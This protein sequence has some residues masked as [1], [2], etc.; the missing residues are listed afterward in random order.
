MR[1]KKLKQKILLPFVCLCLIFPFLF[2]GLFESVG[3]AQAVIIGPIVGLDDLIIDDTTNSV[4][5]SNYNLSPATPYS[6]G[7]LRA[8]KY[9]GVYNVIR[10]T[11]SW[12]G[13]AYAS[14][15]RY[16]K[17]ARTDGRY[18]YDDDGILDVSTSRSSLADEV[19]NYPCYFYAIETTLP[20]KYSAGFMWT[21]QQAKFK[22]GTVYNFSM[23]TSSSTIECLSSSISTETTNKSHKLQTIIGSDGKIVTSGA[24][25]LAI[26]LTGTGQYE[27]TFWGNTGGDVSINANMTNY[28]ALADQNWDNEI[29]ASGVATGTFK[30][31]TAYY[32]PK[33][34]T[35][36]ASN[37]NN[38]V[39][40]NGVQATSQY[41]ST[42]APYTDGH[43]ITISDEGYTTV[44]YENGAEDVWST[45]YCF[46]DSTVPDVEYV[47][48]NSNALDTR[49]VGTI[50]TTSSGA[51]TQ[52]ITEGVFKD[53][54]QVI[55]SYDE[56]ESPETAT[57][58]YGG[59]TYSLTSG[60]WLSADGDYVVTITDAAG[61]TT[62]S[63]F[64]IDTSSPSY[65][66]ARLQSDTTYKV[67]KW[68]VVDIPYGYS[69]YGSYS[70][71]EYDDALAFAI[72]IER[73]NQVTEYTLSNINDFVAT[74]LV[75]SG[76]TVKTGNYWYYK[77]RDNPNL[78]VYYFDESSLEEVLEYYSKD[79]VSD[80]QVYKQNST[81]NPN[82][83]G[84]TLD[85]SMYDNIVQVDGITA[86][87]ANDFVFKQENTNES[88]KIYYSYGS[89]SSWIE[90]KY[91]TKFSS[92]VSTNGLYKI[93]EIDY[94][95]HETYYYIYLDLQSPLIDYEA[96]LYGSDKTITQ[97]ISV[98]DI[99]TNGELIF[100]YE[101]F[102]ITDVIEIDKWWTI[103]IKCP[104]GTTKR[105]TYLDEIPA[106][107]E[108]GTGEFTISVADRNNDAF[109]F[110]VCI[111][112]AA[113]EVTFTALNANSQLQIVIT[114]KDDAN[115]L[116]DL[117]IYRNDVC[118][119]SEQGYDEYPDITTDEL[120]YININTLKYVF[121]R[122]GIY[123]VEVTDSYGRTLTFEY[124]FEKDL[125]TGILSGVQHNGATNG[126]VTFTYNSSKYL[127]IVTQNGNSYSPTQTENNGT[128]ILYFSPT[129]DAE[130]L[131]NIELVE[132]TDTENYNIY[133]FTIDTVK[134]T[135][136]LYGVE[137]GGKTGGSVYATWDS[138]DEQY[139]ATYTLDGLTQEYKKGA[140]LSDAGAYVISLS[141]ELGNTATVSF[142]I[143][144]SVDFVIADAS[145]NTYQISEIEYINF[146]LR[147]VN[148]E[149]LTIS[150]TLDGTEIDYEFGLMITE[151]GYY[152]ATLVDEF[153]NQEYFSFTIDK[154]APIA[155]LYGVENYGIT[156]GSA[157]VA[158]QES[159]LTCWI[160]KDE[161]TNETYKLGTEITATGSYVI[162][163]A[164]KAKNITS[165]E[166]SIDRSV[167]YDI[168]VY[169][170]GITNE[171]V[172]IVAYETLKVV[173]YKDG[174]HI[175]YEFE[176]IL[177]EDGEYSY[178]LIDTY[179]NKTSSYF[180]IL[181][182]KQQN[183]THLLQEGISVQSVTKDDENFDFVITNGSLYLY[184]EGKYVVSILDEE[185]G[186]E[187]SFEVTIDT[188][189]PTLEIVGV[190]NGGNTK[191]V[192][193]LK[194][195]S[196]ENCTLYITVDGIEFEYS[197]G[198]EIEKSGSF[199]VTLTDEAG[200]KTT[201]TFER[202]YSFNAAS[203]AVLAGLGALVVLL[204]IFLI[205][206]RRK[207]QPQ[208]EIEE[209][210]T[211]TIVEDDF[212]DGDNEPPIDE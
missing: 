57:Y 104:D 75:A 205:G 166:F 188:T 35:I 136:N 2:L 142:E 84:N 146:D 147:I 20:I 6:D 139:Y 169:R 163:V 70:F 200:N 74:N 155:T 184:D 108:I 98:G 156:N 93:K 82:N 158:S 116:T 44:E 25:C 115:I 192:V 8:Y 7:A 123:V 159:G 33:E 48:H 203:I 114:N 99:P 173:M 5:Y 204:I 177:T 18:I 72:T 85:E 14:F 141:D 17:I 86:Y 9:I 187:Y 40:L 4:D 52:T 68:Y 103:E 120:I 54:V 19:V 73:A 111:L 87:L 77:S 37:L 198:D 178:T 46:V 109:K 193:V 151:E 31:K 58:T 206:S 133:T 38:Y 149:N 208:E 125:P 145:G 29:I 113:P 161:E 81:L 1:L 143:D 112:G 164:D 135:I 56:D 78:Y 41:G 27:N 168:N 30:G 209:E 50:T 182:K 91:N 55:F 165:F 127:A 171:G 65:N 162:C 183:L 126:E 22:S 174:V 134:P 61:N 144:K 69:G 59:K 79:Y 26:W 62:I 167:A 130:I 89:G 137:N 71:K 88:Y 63:K 191:S 43:H 157:W 34:F 39:K 47:Y 180:T 148:G 176:Q 49:K 110:T 199:I 160:V 186:L 153:G 202:V 150:L 154:T 189:P 76:N 201:Y 66:L 129:E 13:F 128:T 45:V 21:N 140:Y 212:N 124:K 131:Y 12:N 24:T 119:N 138:G 51:K 175:E 36:V 172:R 96:K 211:E 60:T 94:V 179:G 15:C 80:E 194:N 64:T 152:T 42:V 210:L 90:F 100:Y 11:E 32:S 122:G 101:K 106:L 207:Y 10:D 53:Q 185:T 107:E 190:E 97:T 118:L 170:G 23:D 92:Q 95:G 83:Y 196:E 117:K 28:I 105:Y 102:Q 197:L 195:I 132:L 67:A 121:N 181:T 3:T 16:F